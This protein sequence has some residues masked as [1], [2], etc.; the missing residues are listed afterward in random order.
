MSKKLQYTMAV[1]LA[2]ILCVS[3]VAGCAPEA[4]PAEEEPGEE[5]P[6]YHWRLPHHYGPTTDSNVRMLI[7]ADEIEEESNG[8]IIID[9]YPAG[10]LG[11]GEIIW[12][13]LHEGS[14]LFQLNLG[15]SY[16]DIDPR[17]SF[18]YIPWLPITTWEEARSGLG[19]GGWESNLFRELMEESGLKVLGIWP[20]GFEGL[21]L[22]EMPPSLD[23]DVPKDMKLRV[24][25]APGQDIFWGRM[26]FI[27]VQIAWVDVVTSMMT[28]VIDGYAGGTPEHASHDKADCTNVWIQTNYAFLPHFVLANLEF[29]NSLD[30]ETQQIVANAAKRQCDWQFINGE[31]REEE[32]R[33]LQ[34]DLGQE[35]YFFT[36]EEKEK[37]ITTT[38]EEVWPQLEPVFT[39]EL[40]DYLR[41]LT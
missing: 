1:V 19:V 16:G 9:V 20:A 35:I 4:A 41:S 28:G 25:P 7:M 39:K 5:L 29:W 40:F 33:Q 18:Y 11:G 13:Q 27:P 34:R 10:E 24:S 32:Y 21:G 26:G 23:P 30:E 14:D 37:W 12:D 2:S 22:T 15:G 3:A 6:T 38:R 36:A 31:K 8:R 17:L